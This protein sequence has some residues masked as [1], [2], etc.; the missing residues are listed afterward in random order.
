MKIFLP[1]GERWR[2]KHVAV[3]TVFV[4]IMNGYVDCFIVGTE[5]TKTQHYVLCYSYVTAVCYAKLSKTL[6]MLIV[7]GNSFTVNH[8]RCNCVEFY[9]LI[10][11]IRKMVVIDTERKREQT[12]DLSRQ[13]CSSCQ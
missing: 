4:Y 13:L 10:V 5:C 12:R 8:F 6:I 3:R 2:L 9:V 7:S 11:K 1:I